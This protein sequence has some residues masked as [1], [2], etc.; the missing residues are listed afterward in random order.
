MPIPAKV[1]IETAEEILADEMKPVRWQRLGDLC[2]ERLDHR[3][4]DTK[5]RGDIRDQVAWFAGQ[6]KRDLFYLRPD[7]R[8]DI[9]HVCLASWFGKV[10]YPLFPQFDFEFPV[11][12]CR[13]TVAA[14]QRAI[15]E[16]RARSPFM[17]NKYNKNPNCLGADRVA[18]LWAE[19]QVRDQMKELWPRLYYP[20]DNEGRH[21]QWCEH[22]F[23]LLLGRRGPSA[24]VKVDVA[25]PNRTSGWWG[26]TKSG[27]KRG[28]DVHLCVK[29]QGEKVDWCG[30]LRGSDF[31]KGEY[32][33]ERLIPFWRF[34]LWLNCEQPDV[35]ADLNTLLSLCASMKRNAGRCT[36]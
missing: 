17:L 18:A 36:L 27:G 26:A 15:A 30:V 7:S 11:P 28:T 34:E 12:D 23:K 31:E 1:L 25:T 19:Q 16:V 10:A 32:P 3:P 2:I 4:K 9:K 29:V 6:E 35:P 22:D 33:Q 21:S 24:F 5:E 8:P 14:A 20:P 13:L